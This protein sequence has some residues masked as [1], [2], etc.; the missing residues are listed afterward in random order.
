MKKL[1]FSLLMPFITSLC[2]GQL[3]TEGFDDITTLEGNGWIMTNQSNPIGTSNWFQ[4]NSTVFPGH[5]G[6]ASSYIAANYQ[7]TAGAGTISNWLIFPTLSL[8]DADQL[9]FWTRT[10]SNS[11]PD[12][13]EVRAST[14]TMTLPSGATS[15]GSFTN[16]L[17]SI[18]E[19]LG[20]SYPETWTEYT[21][22][23][24]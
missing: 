24:S 22:T 5:Q 20:N 19:S 10:D 1:L 4:G 17:L 23:L 18:N 11:F 6:G 15:V 7:N 8:K 13:L 12:R 3:L 9:K 14:G 2:F 21:V 16:L